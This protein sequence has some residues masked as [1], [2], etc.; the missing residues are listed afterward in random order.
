MIGFFI[1]LSMHFGI[2]TG[3]NEVHPGVKYYENPWSVGAYYNS[4]HNVSVYGSYTFEGP[5]SLEIG[6]ATGYSGA[7]VIPFIRTFTALYDN[8]ILF[9]SPAYNIDTEQFG[10]VV[11]VEFMFK[12]G[13]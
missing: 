4:E 12:R 13:L 9:I 10:F 3:W 11:G 5:I 1:A 8:S 2:G 6:L 7:P